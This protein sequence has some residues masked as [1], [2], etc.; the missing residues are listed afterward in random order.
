MTRDVPPPELDVPDDWRLVSEERQTP[1]DVGVV[2]VDATT[3]IYEDDA[4]R[5]RLA[6]VT[7]TETT[8]RFVFASRLRIR[9][10]TSVSQS[11]TRLVTDR[12]N[13]RFR[14]VL[15]ERGFE[16]I[17]RTDDHRLDV[18]EETADATRYR[19]SVRI[20]GLDVPVEAY[21]AV[22]PDDGAYLLGGGAYPLSLPDPE[23]FDLERGREELFSMLR[24]IR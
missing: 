7:G 1:F 10:A 8:W 5:D 4:L 13:A 9:P 19:A 16:A 23:T 12:A 17:E 20:D 22:W 14:D 2:S 11:L 15:R 24:S 18:G 21:V 6:D 3:R